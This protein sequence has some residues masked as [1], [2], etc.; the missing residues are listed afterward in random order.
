MKETIQ[1][2]TDGS[3]P[4]SDTSVLL[5]DAGGEVGEGFHDG[6]CWRWASATRCGKI[7]AWSDMPEGPK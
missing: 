2:I 6:E 3:L 1:W 7:N 5:Q 4:D